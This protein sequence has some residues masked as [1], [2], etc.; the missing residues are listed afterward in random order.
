[1]PIPLVILSGEKQQAAFSVRAGAS[2]KYEY[3]EGALER[4]R[5]A[6]QKALEQL[7]RLKVENFTHQIKHM[8]SVAQQ[9]NQSTYGTFAGYDEKVFVE[10]MKSAEA[11]VTQSLEIEKGLDEAAVNGALIAFGAYGAVG[12][13]A[14]VSRGTAVADFSRAAATNATLAWL[15]GGA[16]VS[17]VLGIAGDMD[18]LGFFFNG[19]PIICGNCWMAGRGD[20][21]IKEANEYA[22]KVEKALPQMDAMNTAMKAICTAAAEQTAVIMELAEKF[23]EVRV[24]SF[25]D[26]GFARMFIVGKCLKDVLMVP[27]LEED[28]T[29]NP[30]I[31][32]ECSG[33]LEVARRA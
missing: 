15:G 3:A 32:S 21:A 19:L 30:G 31:S 18:P 1:M 24:D 10:E 33:Y 16:H 17:G 9:K 26:S 29:V 25:E 13:S 6:T 8:V 20:Q 4:N 11:I 5:V 7:G 2:S 12:A 23:E 28:G 22:A 14:S 27:V